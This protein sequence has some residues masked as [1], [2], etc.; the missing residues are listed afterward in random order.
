MN[1]AEW[2]MKSV[3]AAAKKNYLPGHHT[4]QHTMKHAL[5]IHSMAGLHPL[6]AFSFSSK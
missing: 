2:R 1:S 3:A 5:A 4:T 6:A